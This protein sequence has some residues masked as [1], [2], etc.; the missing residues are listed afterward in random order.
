MPPANVPALQNFCL[1][2][3]SYNSTKSGGEK[4]TGLK[5]GEKWQYVAS[6]IPGLFDIKNM[7]MLKFILGIHWPNL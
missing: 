5:L 7:E 2:R 6:D 3:T 1:I 4:N